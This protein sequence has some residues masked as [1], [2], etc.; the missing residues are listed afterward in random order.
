[1][2]TFLNFYLSKFRND[3]FFFSKKNC[4]FFFQLFCYLIRAVAHFLSVQF[5]FCCS[6]VWSWTHWR[7]AR[8]AAACSFCAHD[9]AA[10]E[11][12]IHQ[13][14]RSGILF[15]QT[16]FF[17]FAIFRFLC[18]GYLKV[19][20]LKQSL[21]VAHNI[22]QTYFSSNLFSSNP[23][24]TGLDEN[25]LDESPLAENRLDENWAHAIFTQNLYK[26]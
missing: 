17:T 9:P 8:T 1:M 22:R 5:V 25:P 18:A 13:M 24:L 12:N 2:H 19:R 3:R 14:Q 16:N 4:S 21:K 20:N 7:T 23:N 6:L 26:F 15:K 10:S 11:V